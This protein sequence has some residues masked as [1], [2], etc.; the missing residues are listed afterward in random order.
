[1]NRLPSGA[2]LRAGLT[3]M[4]L[5]TAAALAAAAC[6]PAKVTSEGSAGGSGGGPGLTG[7]SGPG[8]SGSG[9]STT[10]GAPGLVL[11]DAGPGGANP[12]PPPTTT[13]ATDVH[14]AE[15]VPLD[16]L[17]L[18]DTSDSMNELSGMQSKWQLTR[19]ALRSFVDDPGSQGLGVGLLFFP[20][21]Q[22]PAQ[23]TCQ[24][25]TE[26]AA[27]SGP[28][29]RACRKLGWCFAPGLPLLTNRPCAPGLVSPFNCPAGMTCRPQG[30][31]PGG[32]ICAEGSPCDSGG[33]CQVTP[34][35]C[36]VTGGGCNRTQYDPLT[37]P[38]EPLPGQAGPVAAALAAREPDGL[39]P[40]T[41]ASDAALTALAARATSHPGRRA[42]LVLA[43]DGLPTGCGNSESVDSVATRLQQARLAAPGIPTY[44]VGVFAMDEVDD[45]RPALE[46]FATAGG[47][48]APFVLTTGDDL[49]QRLLDAL[50]EIRGQAVACE[51]AIPTPQAG[52]IDFNKVN[53]RTNSQGLAQDLTYVASPDRCHPDNGGW[54]YDPAPA[55]GSKPA[56]LVLCPASCA[57][58]RGDP[59]AQVDLVFGC[60]TRTID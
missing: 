25:D 18:V 31:C 27:V 26:C 48:R 28:V 55:M 52:A 49:A 20:A 4:L 3:T 13:C 6:Q 33:T 37:V 24:Q 39:T 35:T 14:R 32:A 50:K 12:A 9:P 16:L 22:P 7:G 21:D 19:Q 59:A 36:L 56:R 54:Y 17:L 47:T 46:R 15:K 29:A 45:A 8:G 57:R 38:I 30:R 40:M 53:V 34:G 5:G 42:A 41:V 60:A 10:G 1:M 43:T 11:P 23:T 58:L 44:V 51:Y 2:R